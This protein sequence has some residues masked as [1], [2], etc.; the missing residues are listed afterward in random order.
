MYLYKLV[1][2]KFENEG[3]KQI[4]ERGVMM[5][6][7]K[8]RR[9]RREKWREIVIRERGRWENKKPGTLHFAK[10]DDD[11]EPPEY[12]VPIKGKGRPSTGCA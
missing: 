9:E 4:S 2:I 12:L 7:K 11:S 8:D 1:G 3:D 6:I 5:E 10:H